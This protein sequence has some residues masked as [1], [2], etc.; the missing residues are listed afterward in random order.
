MLD[1]QSGKCPKSLN[2]LKLQ[3]PKIIAKNKFEIFKTFSIIKY[4]PFWKSE[5]LKFWT[6][7]KNIVFELLRHLL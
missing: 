2:T 7:K 1:I 4:C 3:T 6:L 5:F